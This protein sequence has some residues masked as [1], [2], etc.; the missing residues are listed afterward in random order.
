MDHQDSIATN[1]YQG[2]ET[3]FPAPS[4]LFRRA[5]S[6]SASTLLIRTSLCLPNNPNAI[7]RGNTTI[8]MTVSKINAQYKFPGGLMVPLSADPSLIPGARRASDINMKH[9]P[10]SWPPVQHIVLV[11]SGDT[12]WVISMRYSSTTGTRLKDDAPR[13]AIMVYIAPRFLVCGV[14][15]N[16][17]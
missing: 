16:A 12:G 10:V 13:M 17:R 11:T 2:N 14:H 8:A 7:G 5:A 4:A 6:R 15:V 9:P 1:K 3:P